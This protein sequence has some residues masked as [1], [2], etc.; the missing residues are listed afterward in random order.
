MDRYRYK[1]SQCKLKVPLWQ[2]IK[3]IL[4]LVLPV[5]VYARV[6]NVYHLL[7]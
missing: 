3:Y 1:I 5:P 2:N 4:F 6:S 7:L